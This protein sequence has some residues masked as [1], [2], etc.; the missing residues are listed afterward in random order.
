MSAITRA[1]GKQ[2]GS[3][4]V[5]AMAQGGMA[6]APL[7]ALEAVGPQPLAVSGSAGVSVYAK[8]ARLLAREA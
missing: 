1:L 5:L 7:V 3:I 4:Y 2:E 8:I 6:P